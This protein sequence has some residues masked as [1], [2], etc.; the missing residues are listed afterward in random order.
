M[1]TVARLEE[2][3]EAFALYVTCAYFVISHTVEELRLD[4]NA[5]FACHT[6]YGLA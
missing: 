3:A 2:V 4:E 1:T 6:V 5:L